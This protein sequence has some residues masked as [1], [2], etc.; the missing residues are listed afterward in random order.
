MDICSFVPLLILVLLSSVDKFLSV[1]REVWFPKKDWTK[2]DKWEP[3][4]SFHTLQMHFGCMNV[5][6]Q[7]TR[8]HKD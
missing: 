5:Q 2:V 1:E 3:G 7:K 6:T 8:T 4:E